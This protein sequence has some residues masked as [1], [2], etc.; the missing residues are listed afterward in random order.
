MTTDPVSQRE[1]VKQAWGISGAAKNSGNCL[2]FRNKPD[3]E[4]LFN[5]PKHLSLHLHPIH[6]VQLHQFS[7]RNDNSTFSSLC[8][9]RYP[10]QSTLRCHRSPLPSKM[11]IWSHKIWFV[12][13]SQG[14][15]GGLSP[16]KHI[17]RLRPHV[18]DFGG[19]RTLRT[20]TCEEGSRFP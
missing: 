1:Q 11:Q 9:L 6:L 5:T 15:E 2:G 4:S 7:R 10:L 12:M 14:L 17:L 19:R 20:N 8:L 16:R 13:A 18:G 3:S